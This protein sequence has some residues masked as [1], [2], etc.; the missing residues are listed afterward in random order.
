LTSWV[1]TLSILVTYSPDEEFARLVE[2]LATRLENERF[3][4]RSAV[5]CYLSCGSFA[6]TVRIWASMSH[7]Q[8]SQSQALQDLVEKMSCLFNAV[9]PAN[10]DTV[11]AH[12]VLQ[13][14]TLL[15]NSGRIVAAMRCL[16]LVPDSAET[17]ILKDRIFNAAPSMM[18]QLV[19][20]PPS[21]P[22]EVLDIHPIQTGGINNRHNKPSQAHMAYA[23]TGP[24]ALV[25]GAP[26]GSVHSR[27]LGHGQGT[28]P[29]PSNAPVAR[30]PGSLVSQ[31]SIPGP[32]P[33]S[34]SGHIPVNPNLSYP[35]D[36]QGH[37]VPS[38]ASHGATPFQQSP[39]VPLNAI[40]SRIT[41]AVP[42]NPSTLNAPQG[43]PQSVRPSP[44]ATPGT[45]RGTY[46]NS[47][48][49]QGFAPGPAA[50]RSFP[51]QSVSGQS[52][53]GPYA[54]NP[55]VSHTSSGVQGVSL[56]PASGQVGVPTTSHRAAIGPPTSSGVSTAPHATANPV[57]TGMPVSWPIPTPVQQQL[58]PGGAPPPKS[59]A[60]PAP[61][62]GEP[63]PPGD[64]SNIQRSL[65]G[66]LERCAQDGNR[67]KWE[68]TGNKLNELYRMLSQGLISRESV[69]KVKELCIAVER[70]DFQTASRLRV[71]LS[72]SDW[73]KNRTWLFAI[74]LLLPK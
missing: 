6:N 5:L 25:Q 12:K 13:Y 8:G 11:F 18:G 50:Q 58:Y 49:A 38:R 19:R 34:A 53:A 73:E 14:S 39:S 3:D 17:R 60:M 61:V 69:A 4:V 74:Q 21:F 57:T 30:G 71:E 15:A 23:P 35:S 9:R 48:A 7:G 59:A 51:H 20:Q 37:H 43:I 54:S 45:G 64:I 63:V 2:T 36:V 55:V 27:S 46:V 40:P 16:L 67:K 24:G 52:V 44:P 66:L 62:S 47:P 22:F 72:A 29:L 33:T 28:L 65:T 32:K 41:P 31:P 1:E 56:P 68:D 70:S 26:S 10:V 42:T